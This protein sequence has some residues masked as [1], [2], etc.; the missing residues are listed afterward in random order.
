MTTVKNVFLMGGVGNQLFQIARACSHRENGYEVCIL[1]LSRNKKSI[2][3]LI[4]FTHHDDWIDIDRVLHKLAFKT[5]EVSYSQMLFVLRKLGVNRYFDT[6]IDEAPNSYK[7]FIDVGYYQSKEHLTSN[8]VKEVGNALIDLLGI[9]SDKDNA[10]IV[11]HI[12]GGDF[13]EADRLKD[14]DVER[15]KDL[16]RR[17]KLKI[18]V[19]TNDKKFALEICGSSENI[20]VI[21]SSSARDDFIFLGRSN[22]LFLSNSTFAFWAATV[23]SIS[24]DAELFASNS[25]PWK[26]LINLVDI[27]CCS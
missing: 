11:L 27:N 24:N 5:K 25:F 1:Q 20:F 9:S 26:P 15:V 13:F 17:R 18:H 7:K 10:G 6:K 21:D 16:A 14:Y 22:V 4:G 2:Y 3:R 8:S 19:V 23:A 12:R